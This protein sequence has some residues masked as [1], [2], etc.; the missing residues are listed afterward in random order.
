MYAKVIRWF[1]TNAVAA[2]LL[3]VSILLIGVLAIKNSIPLEVFP[4][5]KFDAVQVT[6]VFPGASPEDVEKGITIKIEEAIHDLEG[7]K[8]ITSRS[9]EFMSS[10][11][12]KVASG[13]DKKKLLD[14]IKLRVDG[15][16]SLPE[17]A[18]RPI[19]Q[20]SEFLLEVMNVVI[21][22]D[23]PRIQLLS[24]AEEIRNELIQLKGVSTVRFLDKPDLEI[25][26]EITPDTL[27][28]YG[29]SMSQI[30]A[31]I[32]DHLVE[33][34]AGNL[35]TRNGN[36]LVR[37]NN[38]AYTRD[39]FAVVPIIRSN[40]SATVLLGQI[41]T[42]KDGFEELDLVTLFN[43]QP[44]LSLSVYRSGKE[45]AVTAAKLVRDYIEKKQ[46]DLPSSIELSYWRDSSVIVKS[47][48]KTLTNSAIQGGILVI[49]LL[50]LFLRPAVA[51]WV[52]LGIPV[53]FMGAIAVMP[54]FSVSFNMISLFG[55]IL[56]L[57]IVVDDAIVTGENIFKHLRRGE[58]PLT[59][60]INGTEEVAIPVT[61]GVLTTVAAFTPLLLIEGA[62]GEL[63]SNI[64]L[65][66]IPVLL[67]SL[68]ESKLILP[69]HM[70]HIKIRSTIENSNALSRWQ[71]GF[72]MGFEKAI[73]TF[74]QPILAVCLRNKIITL[75]GSIVFSLIV[76][77]AIATG[78]MKFVFFPD[79]DD[80]AVIATITMP[81]TSG[82]AATNDQVEHLI[83]TAKELQNDYRNPETGKSLIEY[84]VSFA[85]VTLQGQLQSNTGFVAFEIQDPETRDDVDISQLAQQW[86]KKIGNIAGAEKLSIQSKIADVGRPIAIQ[87]RGNDEASLEQVASAL[88][89]H[90]QEY[91]SLFDIQNNQADGKEEMRVSLAEKAQSLGLSQSDLAVQL[92]STIFGY[93][94]QKFIR[95]RDEVTVKLRYP[96]EYRST[97]DDLNNLPIQLNNRST[98]QLSEVAN[99]QTGVSP[100]AYRRFNRER[101]YNISADL[102][103]QNSDIE[104]IKRETLA[105]LDQQLLNYP[106]V[107]YEL[108]GEAKEQQEAFGSLLLGIFAVLIVIFALLAIPFRSYW[109]PLI[110][111]SIIPLGF[112]GAVLGHVIMNTN[113]S[114]LSFMG[115]L[116]LTG[117]VVNDSLVLV[118]YI[119]RQRRQG[120]E[121]MAAVLN[122]GVARFRPVMLT[123][124]TTFAGL[125]PILAEKSTQAQFLKPMAISLAFGILFATLITL[126]IVPVNY[127]LFENAGK[128][129]KRQLKK[130]FLKRVVNHH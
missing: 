83:A 23:M 43:G 5:F 63:F 29:L 99:I 10:V 77:T 64:P 21:S 121:I 112:V 30:A 1:A 65:I 4:A 55:F 87:L 52:C 130:L 79:V 98:I 108:E 58:Q 90:W 120:M 93:D 86:R 39:D 25:S 33:I 126:V 91:P 14:E 22:G 48:L 76:F 95:G 19:I 71:H 54:L 102:D 70:Q 28:A 88:E 105:F 44:S 101:I 89:Q 38:R 123:S 128:I 7:I 110:V 129:I 40:Q 16:N 49:L 18:E 56:V 37:T 51:F 119:N 84:I 78:W 73:I 69:A 100:A 103:K 61:F 15:L 3:M 60:A 80:E 68:V 109:Q 27:K 117:V 114:L 66:A 75:L 107:S 113:L 47:R 17:N 111:M 41:A 31:I 45:S 97:L 124:I 6:T 62:S 53:S 46:L 32:N 85:G 115:M 12:A 104:A 8:E 20:E 50:S 81:A 106:N 125:T 116:A 26:I 11:S 34:S 72:S 74:Y 118:D 36:I 57:G 122:A 9:A 92:R 24:T 127:V 13:Y 82:F 94:V 96:K 42:I 67:F 59:A 35:K 2:N